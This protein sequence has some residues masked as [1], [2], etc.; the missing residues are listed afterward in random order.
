MQKNIP[1]Y[2][3]MQLCD[4][5]CPE[6]RFWSSFKPELLQGYERQIVNMYCAPFAHRRP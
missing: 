1:V 5:C 4:M 3:A 2:F 6:N